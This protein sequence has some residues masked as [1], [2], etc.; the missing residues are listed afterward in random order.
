MSEEVE[1]PVPMLSDDTEGLAQNQN[2]GMTIEDEQIR[3]PSEAGS[4]VQEEEDQNGIV[5]QGDKRIRRPN[6][7]LT[8]EQKEEVVQFLIRNEGLYNKRRELWQN[9][10]KK[11][12]MWQQLGDALGVEWKNLYTWHESQRR[13]LS[14]LKVLANKFIDY[15]YSKFITTFTSIQTNF[16]Y[17]CK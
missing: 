1:V 8:N 5:I 12:E 7:L 10:H 2:G 13:R 15:I 6:V 4:S 3:D 17:T 16:P 11:K 14:R 9:P